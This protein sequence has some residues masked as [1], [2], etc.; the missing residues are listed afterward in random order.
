MNDKLLDLWSGAISTA[1][2]QVTIFTDND[3]SVDYLAVCFL[4]RIKEGGYLAVLPNY[5]DP[6]GPA[7]P[8]EKHFKELK[9]VEG[10]DSFLLAKDQGKQFYFVEPE[11]D[12]VKNVLALFKDTLAEAGITVDQ[13]REIQRK[14]RSIPGERELI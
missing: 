8:D 13:E 3:N 14:R 12:L 9:F 1:G 10:K 5:M 7:S 11:Q 2:A 6:Y 4:Y